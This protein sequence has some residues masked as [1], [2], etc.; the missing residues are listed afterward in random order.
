MAARSAFS[1]G[2]SDLKTASDVLTGW[3]GETFELSKR[4]DM[5]AEMLVE[6]FSRRFRAAFSRWLFMN[7]R[8]TLVI[9]RTAASFSAGVLA[10]SRTLFR[11]SWSQ[12]LMAEG[13]VELAMSE[14]KY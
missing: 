5:S 9:S 14:L 3:A 6:F 1:S 10:L 2:T 7:C 4:D 11:R 12:P 8:E 13:S